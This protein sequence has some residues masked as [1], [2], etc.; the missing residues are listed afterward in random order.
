MET[1]AWH[2]DRSSEARAVHRANAN[3]WMVANATQ[4][5]R[6]ARWS[7]VHPSNAWSSI[8]SS[9]RG[10]DPGEGRHDPGEGARSAT[11]RA[12]GRGPSRPGRGGEGEG[13]HGVRMRPP[14]GDTSATPL[15]KPTRGP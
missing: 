12:R 6:S 13:R 5:G 4:R 10:H 1:S 3:A 9:E 7:W 8:D 11:T 15:S 2:P 14:A